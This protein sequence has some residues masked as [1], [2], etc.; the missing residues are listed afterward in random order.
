[1]V[2]ASPGS[3]ASRPGSK[4]GSLYSLGLET[5]KRT[6]PHRRTGLTRRPAGSGQR[7]LECLILVS[8]LLQFGRGVAQLAAALLAGASRHAGVVTAPVTSRVE[9]SCFSAGQTAREKPDGIS[10]PGERPDFVS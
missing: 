2:G 6:G 1:M 4:N 5:P 10:R 8:S 7:L 3:L 9:P